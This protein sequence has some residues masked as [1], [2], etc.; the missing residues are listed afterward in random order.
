MLRSLHTICDGRLRGGND[1]RTEETVTEFH[2]RT[3][4]TNLKQVGQVPSAAKKLCVQCPRSVDLKVELRVEEIYHALVGS[5]D[6]SDKTRICTAI[7]QKKQELLVLKERTD[8]LVGLDIAIKIFY[9]PVDRATVAMYS[10]E[11][12]RDA[13]FR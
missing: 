5:E 11:L 3:G 7:L 2:C 8:D 10:G 4:G 13:G 6:G 9:L 1:Y 12:A